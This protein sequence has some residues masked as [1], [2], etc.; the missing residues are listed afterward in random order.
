MAGIIPRTRRST[1]TETS[2]PVGGHQARPVTDWII[3][4]SIVKNRTPPFT[5]HRMPKSTEADGFWPLLL[6]SAPLRSGHSIDL[7]AGIS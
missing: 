4:S 6:C 1:R 2:R 7:L 5:H 3:H